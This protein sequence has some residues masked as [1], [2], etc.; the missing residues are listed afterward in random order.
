MSSLPRTSFSRR[1]VLQI[2]C[3]GFA[4]LSLPA[5]LAG[6]A[7][8]A[9]NSTPPRKPKSVILILLTGGAA[10]QDTFDLKP[11]APEAV[12]SEFKPIDTRTPGIQLC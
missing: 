5:V 11:E 4:G 2:G 12:R 10:H 1:K 8:A 6:R 7:K 3:S 9:A